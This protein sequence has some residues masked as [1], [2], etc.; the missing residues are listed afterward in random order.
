MACGKDDPG[1]EA[2]GGKQSAVHPSAPVQHGKIAIKRAALQLSVAKDCGPP[3]FCT[4]MV[5]FFIP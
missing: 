1:S 2:C 5:R 3:I 4:P